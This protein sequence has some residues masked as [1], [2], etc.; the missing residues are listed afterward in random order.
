MQTKKTLLE[1]KGI[2]EAKLIKIQEA[3]QKV[4]QW[5]SSKLR[6]R[7]RGVQVVSSEAERSEAKLIGLF[8]QPQ[9]H[10][11]I[12][13]D[14]IRSD[15]IRSDPIRSDPIRSDPIR[16]DPI[17]SDQIAVLYSHTELLIESLALSLAGFHSHCLLNVVIVLDISLLSFHTVRAEL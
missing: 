10:D 17:R 5:K 1:I 11:S 4:S 16:S 14:P 12:R 13:S 6:H 9:P 8:T 2:T 7:T 15:P 3:V